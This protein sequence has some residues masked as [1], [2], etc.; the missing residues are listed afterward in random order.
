MPNYR[1]GVQGPQRRYVKR[2]KKSTDA[3]QTKDIKVLKKTDSLSRQ[4]ATRVRMIYVYYRDEAPGA[5]ITDILETVDPTVSGTD[6]VDNFY[7]RNG[8]LK[9]KVLKDVV[10]N[11]Q[12]DYYN[13]KQTK[14]ATDDQF[15]G[16]TSV[17]P[18][19]K[20]IRH[21]L[22]LS[23]LPNSGRANWVDINPPPRLGQIVLFTMSDNIQ[24]DVELTACTQLT[25]EDQ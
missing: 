23:K 2:S 11:L 15:S 9:Y 1:K 14:V 19:F 13:Y 18:S 17:H 7:K 21:T 3:K 8:R 16:L 5:S 6:F 12:A 10:Y 4:Q 25:W 20:T 22:D 24:F